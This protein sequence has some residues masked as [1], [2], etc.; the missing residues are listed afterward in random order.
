[1]LLAVPG[2]VATLILAPWVIRIFYTAEFLP[3][4]DLLRWFVFGCLGRVV[5]WPMGFILLAKG[6]GRLFFASETTFGIAH[7]TLVWVGLK[8]FGLI[9]VAVAFVLLY[10]F[11]TAF[12][13][14]LSRYLIGFRWNGGVRTLC[15]FLI[16]PSVAVFAASSLL[17]VLPA[18][19]LGGAI[20]IAV[21][22]YCLRQL[23]ARLGPDHRICRMVCYVPWGNRI[24][25]VTTR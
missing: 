1:L 3:A 22:L 18:T 24:V 6:R 9:G 25:G 19:L 12:M 11:C 7:V 8:F 21:G 2:L 23:A 14:V 17:P 10:I 15:V 16:P 20:A 5:S 13:L 4:V